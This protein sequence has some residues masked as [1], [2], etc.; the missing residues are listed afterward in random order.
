MP[1][2]YQALAQENARLLQ[3]NLYLQALQEHA[4]LAQLN[5]M[6]RMQSTSFAPPGLEAPPAVQLGAELPHKDSR[7]G[8][9]ERSSPEPSTSTGSAAPSLETSR[10]ASENGDDDNQIRDG[11]S[12]DR[13]TV[14]MKNLP[15]NYTR[16]MLLKLLEIEE[17]SGNFDMVYVPVDFHSNSGLGYAFVNLTAPDVAA[18]FKRHFTGF[19]EWCVGSDKVCDVTWSNA[20]QGLEAHIERYRNSPVMHESVPDDHRPMLFE[21]SKQVPFPPPTKKIRAPRKWNRRH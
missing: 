12:V 3:E 21:D 11:C 18:K 7:S 1:L 8:C 5:A 15:N 6:L 10:A 13:T 20:I 16:D 4:R 9:V 19:R 17:F 2:P 14:M